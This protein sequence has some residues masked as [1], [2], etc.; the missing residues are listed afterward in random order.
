MQS[1]FILVVNQ[2]PQHCSQLENILD[3]AKIA[4]KTVL[5]PE[6]ALENLL[7]TLPALILLNGGFR[8][9]DTFSFV[10]RLEMTKINISIILI[11][12][13]NS[14]EETPSALEQKIYGYIET[15]LNRNQLL[16]SIE[17]ALEKRRLNQENYFLKN[18]L[19]TPSFVWPPSS[20]LKAIKQKCHTLLTHKEPIL[21]TGEQGTGKETLALWLHQNS[22]I[23]QK[24]P[25][26]KLN[27][28][29]IELGGFNEEFFGT[30]EPGFGLVKPGLLDQA[31][32]GTLLIQNAE[33]LPK[34]MQKKLVDL[35]R[36][37][38]FRRLQGKPISLKT[39]IILSS[40]CNNNLS[41]TLLDRLK[42]NLI[43]IPSLQERPEDISVLADHYWRFF[44]EKK[45][46]RVNGV[47]VLSCFDLEKQRWSGNMDELRNTVENIFL[48]NRMLVRDPTPLIKP[49]TPF[50]TTYLNHP[51]KEARSL[52]EK[53]YIEAQIKRFCGNIKKTA[54]FVGMERSAFHR[55]IRLFSIEKRQHQEAG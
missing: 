54:Q 52:F 40:S 9:S 17:R 51:L 1:N 4:F 3:E 6:A 49:Y 43:A 30:E 25:F 36:D 37:G 8:K 22:T 21:I 7:Q 10:K 14:L 29:N 23:T 44:E 34:E 19:K 42:K 16:L 18:H 41:Q 31:S 11:G 13:R 26:I 12:T 32:G 53:N 27:A 45:H 47:R 46:Y 39:R 20:K 50:P 48:T 24:D 33:E 28:R 2:T 5:S 38:H 55:K 35:V 15:P